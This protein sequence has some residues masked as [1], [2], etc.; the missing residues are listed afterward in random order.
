MDD[1]KIQAALERFR[2][3]FGGPSPV[4]VVEPR[5]P[6][7]FVKPLTHVGPVRSGTLRE[8]KE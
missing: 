1:A 7:T 2:R 5:A 3:K 6:G 8:V 4:F